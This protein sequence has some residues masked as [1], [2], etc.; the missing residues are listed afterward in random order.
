MKRIHI[1]SSI[2]ISVLLVSTAA[3]LVS[4]SQSSSNTPV[5]DSVYVGIAFCG[6]TT[7]QA[8]LIIDKTKSYTNLFIL[9]SGVN[10]ISRNAT[11]TIEI[12]D[13]ATDA[14][15]NIIVN[16]GSYSRQTWQWEMDL[17]K[18]IK[19]KYGDKFLGAYYDDEPGGVPLDWNWTQ[20]FLINSRPFGNY[21]E[22]IQNKLQTAKETGVTPDNYTIEAQWFQ[23]FLRR[24]I[25]HS[26]LKN[27][28]IQ[29]FTSDYALYWFD[30]L[31]GYDT[32]LVQLG[33]N[34]SDNQ[35]ISLIRGAATMQNKTWGAIITWRYMQ[36]PYLDTADNIYRQMV[37]S[38]DSGAKYITIF[39][40]PYNDTANPYGA[41]TEDHFEALERFWTQVVTK[42]VPNSA[43]AEAALVLPKDYGAAL[44]KEEKIWGIWGPD[45]KSPVIWDNL[46]KLLDQYG[47]RL[48]I[49]YD[50]PAYPI[51]GNYSK[52][53]Y[54]NQ[55]IP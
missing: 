8:K 1:L 52:V 5:K 41:M 28:S 51:M 25:G 20:E 14:G 37:A 4:Y 13:Y 15:L 53:Y 34:I 43:Q 17:F 50:D 49:I 16:L 33:W 11:A 36:P 6:N 54:W 21:T 7:D 55:T 26:D 39:N 31:G 48:D 32:M 27:N 44:R 47:F 3:L 35:Q 38:Y 45:D 18:Q 19:D 2:L 29:T 12:C 23:Q 22:L 30:Y 24:N 42:R 9:D 46:Q 40:Y 10:A